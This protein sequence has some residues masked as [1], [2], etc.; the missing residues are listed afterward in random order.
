[1]GNASSKRFTLITDVIDIKKLER[2]SRKFLYLGFVIAVLLHSGLAAYFTL[3]KPLLEEVKYIPVE[4]FVRRPKITRPLAVS[5]KVLQK[6]YTF[7]KKTVPGKPSG[8]IKTKSLFSLAVPDRLD[9]LSVDYHRIEDSYVWFEKE[10]EAERSLPFNIFYEEK[11]TRK[12]EKHFTPWDELITLD[13]IDQLGIFKGFVIKDPE[14]K[15]NIK[16]FIHIPIMMR[17]GLSGAVT[18]LVETVNAY[19]S[20]N[21]KID[22]NISLESE[23]LLKYPFMYF[24]SGTIF[25]LNEKERKNF[26]TYLKG[27]GFAFLDNYEPWFEFRPGEASLYLMLV[28]ALG[29]DFEFRPVPHD[30]PV[31]YSFF[32]FEG[33]VPEGAEKWHS[34]RDPGSAEWGFL[35]HDIFTYRML[36][37]ISK[38]V[39][40][41]PYSLWGVWIDGRL[42][43]IYSDKGYGHIWRTGVNVFRYR[44]FSSSDGSHYNF[45]PQLKVGLNVMVFALIREGSAAEQMIEY[46]SNNQLTEER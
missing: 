6:K 10:E 44:D 11:I 7:R 29:E 45:N 35:N 32:D 43:A 14:D 18:G 13:D 38:K 5:E 36:L 40:T 26:G 4:L 46:A 2:E 42:A 20:I 33:L 16:G 34:F 22:Y 17:S 31:N 12:P 28:D 27:G 23:N 8:K 30:H 3:R 9:T 37:R 19:T 41:S 39:S 21:A 25:R 1:M 24:S 15:Q